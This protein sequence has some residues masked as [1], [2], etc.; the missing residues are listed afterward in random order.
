MVCVFVHELEC[1]I[2]PSQSLHTLGLD[3]WVRMKNW[4]LAAP[5]GQRKI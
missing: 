4:F 3:M 2:R 5:L 1:D